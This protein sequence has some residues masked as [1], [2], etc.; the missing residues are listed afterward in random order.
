MDFYA[1]AFTK[2]LCVLVH[3]GEDNDFVH[4]SASETTLEYFE[5]EIRHHLIA[6]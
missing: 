4:R 3:S 2:P 5:S 6:E 1:G